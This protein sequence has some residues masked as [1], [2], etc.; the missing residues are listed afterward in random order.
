ME[1][2]LL[3]VAAVAIVAAALFTALFPGIYEV[4]TQSGTLSPGITWMLDPQAGTLTVTGTGS[5]P[6]QHYDPQTSI[7]DTPWY[8]YRQL[9][10][11]VVI[12][13]GITALGKNMLREC[14]W[15]VSVTLPEG[16]TQIGDSCF[17]G[18]RR[19][20]GLKLPKTVTQIG[21]ES[22]RDCTELKVI[23]FPA[24][25]TAIGDHA[26]D[27]CTALKDLVFTGDLPVFGEEPF[28]GV[29]AKA[30]YPAD[31][32]NW[33]TLVPQAGTIQWRPYGD[34]VSS[35]KTVTLKFPTITL[36]AAPKYNIYF[37]ATGLEEIP[38][39]EMGLA[40]L[41]RDPM[42]GGAE[43][44]LDVITGAEH[45]SEAG[46]YMVS[47]HRIHPEDLKRPF[48]F[49][50]FAR[51]PDGTYIRSEQKSCDLFTYARSVLPR[52]TLGQAQRQRLLSLLG[53][54]RPLTD[55]YA[56]APGQIP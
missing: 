38:L 36:G 14:N 29:N 4:P 26:F 10:Q 13:P 35:E 18:L 54:D 53:L 47:T 3:A 12:G 9:I 37:T 16:L 1:K 50:A 40:V 2:K 56:H 51:L 39:S 31:Q 45:N 19:L 41:D 44:I 28:R 27:G 33:A 7:A 11:H 17:M 30:L 21:A 46:L 43:R 23:G 34:P 49:M 32:K 5:V 25:V 52:D 42:G 22:F 8:P 55:L 15:T 20:A 24:S 48:W 6:D